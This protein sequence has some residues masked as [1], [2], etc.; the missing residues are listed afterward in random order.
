MTPTSWDSSIGEKSYRAL[1]NNIFVCREENDLI[2]SADKTK[3]ITLEFRKN[4][5]PL[6]SL[7]SRGLR[8]RGLL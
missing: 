4:P 1:V 2:L 6:H 8:W 3:E 5:P 7:S